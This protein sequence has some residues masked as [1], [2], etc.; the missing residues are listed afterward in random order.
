MVTK[1]IVAAITPEPG[2]AD[3]VEQALEV[4][5]PPCAGNPGVFSTTCIGT[6]RNWGDS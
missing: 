3:T 5:C 2:H 6:S 1:F 4:S